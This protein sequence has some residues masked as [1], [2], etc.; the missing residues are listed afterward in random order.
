MVKDAD[1]FP[2]RIRSVRFRLW[3]VHGRTASQVFEPDARLAAN[4][5]HLAFPLPVD[6]FR[7][8]TNDLRI[9]G[10]IDVEDARGRRLVI[11][12]H[13][14]P[15]IAP[16]PLEI[17]LLESPLPYPSGWRA[18]ELHCHSEF[19]SDHVEFGAPL[20]LMQQAA[21]A[22]GLDFVLCTD[23][24]YD[25]PFRRER[26]LEPRDPT[27]AFAE[28]RAQ[29]AAL[30][31]A[32]PGLPT[33]IPGEE[34]SCGNARGENVHLLAF[35]HP[36]FIP[37]NGDG[38]RQ[39]LFRNRPDL[40]IGEALERLGDTPSFA[41]HP[42]G[43][44]SR[45][46]R[47]ILRRGP[48]RAEDV[49]PDAAGRA[50]RGLQ[51]WNGNLGREYHDG[52]A[53]WVTEL[54]QGRRPLP[55]GADDAHGD[56]NR[57][58][59]VRTPLVSLRESRGHLFGRVRTV[60]PAGGRDAESLKRAFRG[61]ECVCTDGPFGSLSFENGSLRVAAESTRDF[62][63]LS[64]VTVLGAARGEESERVLASWNLAASGEGPLG[65]DERLPFPFADGYARLEVA[66]RR[67]RRALTAGVFF[68]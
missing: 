12:N 15:G 39:G 65:L 49:R 61:A 68:D 25:F 29:A 66:T 31:A 34:V 55:I 2:V 19:T 41:A 21:D 63:A 5:Q 42:A 28:Y 64:S 24:S 9:E 59:W 10:E 30:N 48:W 22:V 50:V 1:K 47:L 35:G 40:S 58:I 32:H 26:Y 44:K 13:N 14:Y 11:R 62:G 4:L 67:G 3:D 33:L 43:H 17:Q 57:N 27:E 8:P 16:S 6:G 18:G 38:G 37:G 23:H 56:F 54:L 52:K 46:Q 7:G 36:E 53:L 51:F 60:V 20:A 45:M